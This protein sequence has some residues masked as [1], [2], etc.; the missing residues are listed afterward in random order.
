MVL[1][2]VYDELVSLESAERDY[3]VVFT[4]SLDDDTLAVDHDATKKLRER[5]VSQNQA[6]PSE[7][8]RGLA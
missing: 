2:D 1:D 6:R 7:D 8:Q 5:Q 4:G 3:G